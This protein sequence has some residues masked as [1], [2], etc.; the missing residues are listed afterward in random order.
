[1]QNGL[2]GDEPRNEHLIFLLFKT[3]NMEMMIGFVPE[4][5]SISTPAYKRI[6]YAWTE[7]SYMQYMAIFSFEITSD[8]QMAI[9]LI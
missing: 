1:L 6:A 4:D 8:A 3:F 2:F 7:D 9:S 5:A